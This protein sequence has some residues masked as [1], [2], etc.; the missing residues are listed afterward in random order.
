MVD[1]PRP[2]RSR[3][4]YFKLR[5]ALAG[6]PDDTVGLVLTLCVLFEDLRLELGSVDENAK[7]ASNLYFIRRSFATL[8]EFA[9]VI[10]RLNGTA[11][12]EPVRRGFSREHRATWNRAV[13]YLAEHKARIDA[14]RNAYGGHVN[15][16]AVL[17][18]FKGLQPG[19]DQDFE[20][21][22]IERERPVKL[23]PRFHFAADIM[24][25]VMLHGDKDGTNERAYFR[26]LMEFSIAGHNHATTCVIMLTD[27]YL[28]R[29]IPM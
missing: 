24:A 7:D 20:L 12:F 28:A 11:S 22:W 29:F 2:T 5:Q 13:E 27:Q 3:T 14:E 8:R 21:H 18:A 16:G 23:G 10:R 9:D 26:S 19:T 6:Q 25:R 4:V 15:Q 17:K 1:W